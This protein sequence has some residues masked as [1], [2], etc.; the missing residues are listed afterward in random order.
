MQKGIPSKLENIIHSYTLGLR[1]IYGDKL[2]SVTLFGSYARGDFTTASDIDLLVVTRASEAEFEKL[3]KQVVELTFETNMEHDI[4]IE[5]VI[6]PYSE[7]HYW[8]AVHPLLR[9]VRKDGVNL[10]AA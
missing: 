5:P 3:R 1:N 9:E 7:Y 2:V 6:M 4:E 8:E 10:Y